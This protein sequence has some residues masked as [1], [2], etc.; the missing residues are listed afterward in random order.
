VSFV[1]AAARTQRLSALTSCSEIVAARRNEALQWEVHVVRHGRLASAGVIPPGADARQWTDRL[2]SDAE[3]V[4]PGFGPAPAATPEETEKILRW[5]EFP[6]VRLVRV[7]GEWSCP[8]A[9][10]E[11]HRDLLD[12][13]S[14]SRESLVPFDDPRVSSTLA[15]PAR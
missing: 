12:S 14:A 11:S 8:L 3:T 13:I 1:R 9:G 2:T 4:L 10:A 15:R 5:L 6:G 7:D